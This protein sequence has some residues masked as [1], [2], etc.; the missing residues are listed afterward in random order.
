MMKDEVTI[1]AKRGIR[2]NEELIT[3]DFRRHFA[4]RTLLARWNA[5]IVFSYDAGLFSPGK[6][7][8]CI[9]ALGLR[10]DSYVLFTVSGPI[11]AP[12]AYPV[13][14]NIYVKCS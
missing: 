4:S 7:L 10:S 14:V 9:I 6:W 11:A 2:E 3:D 12:S 1:S 5:K 13:L 8:R